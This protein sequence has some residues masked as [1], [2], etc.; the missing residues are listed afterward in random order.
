MWYY[1]AT[2]PTEVMQNDQFHNNDIYI[3]FITVI[4]CFLKR[5]DDKTLAIALPFFN[6]IAG[7]LSSIALNSTIESRWISDHFLFSRK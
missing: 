3:T 1:R 2:T 6:I 5:F 7:M 4:H